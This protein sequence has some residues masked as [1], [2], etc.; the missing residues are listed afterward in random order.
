MKDLGQLHHFLG[1]HVQRRPDGFLLSRHQYMLDIL[2]HAGI[3]G[4][5]DPLPPAPVGLCAC[6][7]GPV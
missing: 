2:D 6:P 5:W 3:Y 1:M 7:S 4:P